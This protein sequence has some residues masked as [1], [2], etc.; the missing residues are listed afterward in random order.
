M[1]SKPGQL[2]L[3]RLVRGQHELL[4]IATRGDMPCPLQANRLPSVINSPRREHSRKPDKAYELIEGM[5]PG[6]PKIELFARE[7][8]CGWE[9]WGNEVTSRCESLNH[10]LSTNV[11]IPALRYDDMHLN[12]R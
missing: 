8:R 12:S 5:Y 9:C 11:R 1:S 4:F 7:R 6:L 3:D 10:G 2:H